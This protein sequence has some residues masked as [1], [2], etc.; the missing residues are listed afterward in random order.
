MLNKNL[1]HAD[2]FEQVDKTVSINSI[3]ETVPVEK[4]QLEKLIPHGQSMCLLDAVEFWDR[5]QIRCRAKSVFKRNNPMLENGHL[6]TAAL[7]EY[8]AQAAAIHSGLIGGIQGKGPT[9][10]PR[11]AYLGAVR[12]A[13]FFV[14]QV[15][16]NV[17]Q[18]SVSAQMLLNNTDGA[19][20][21]FCVSN[22]SESLV[23]GRLTVINQ[24]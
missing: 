16:D 11:P 15:A 23:E 4:A 13:R 9:A 12:G 6:Y 20:Y 2:G 18:L 10:A 3:N 17:D 22:G 8:G 21:T 5:Q 1:I 14:E 19:V 7:I 24:N